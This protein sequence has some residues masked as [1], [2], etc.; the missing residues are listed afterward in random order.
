MLIRGVAN[1]TVSRVAEL[2][3]GIRIVRTRLVSQRNATRCS[4]RINDGRKHQQPLRTCRRNPSDRAAT[5]RRSGNAGHTF[6]LKHINLVVSVTAIN[7]AALAERIT[8]DHAT[9]VGIVVQLEVAAAFRNGLEL[10]L[11][12]ATP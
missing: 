6:L 7:G 2:I 1:L 11:C 8:I 3:G 5:C 10:F 9:N 12:A 4:T